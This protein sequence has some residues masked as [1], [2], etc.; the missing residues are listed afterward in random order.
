VQNDPETSRVLDL[1]KHFVESE[2]AVYPIVEAYLFG[3][4]A[5]GSPGED[6]DID[7]GI[8]VDGEVGPAM[9]S[10]IF[11]DA[12]DLNFRLETHVFSKASFQTARRAMIYDMK[13][14]GIRIA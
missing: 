4:W 3:S 10:R 12:Q 13:Q 8:I 2:K 6:S 14:K 11:S 9:E 5:Y 1:V 7:V